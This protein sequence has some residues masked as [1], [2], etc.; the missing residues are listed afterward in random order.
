MPSIK[1]VP[2]VIGHRGACAYAPENTLASF[3]KAKQ[4]G[5]N[6]V[7][8]DVMLTRDEQVVVIHDETIDRTTNA[9]GEVS[10]LDWSYL[11]TLDAGSWFN[12]KFSGEKILLLSEVI[13]FLNQHQ[14]NAN[15]EIKE[16]IGREAITVK[17]V[18]Q[19]IHQCWQEKAP[20]PL[21][22]S[23]SLAV[24]EAVRVNSSTAQLGFLM[25]E[26]LPDWENICDRLACISVNINEKI[27]TSDRVE[28]IRSTDRAVLS[29][30][31]NNRDRAKELFSWGVDAVFSDCPDEIM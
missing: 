13:A 1:I 23:F 3:L 4:L 27:L 6:W 9:K 5:V 10:A 15:I 21:I 17:K 12:K 20:P 29:Y 2:P 11:Q 18:M 30:T 14:L 31:V 24:L 16:S 26:W 19:V 8:F 22:S 25:R 28:K 7:E